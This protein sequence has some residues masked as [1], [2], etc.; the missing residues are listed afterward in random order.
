MRRLAPDEAA[1]W[2]RVIETVKPLKGVVVAPPSNPIPVKGEARRGSGAGVP[3]PSPALAPKPA[4][5]ARAV[6]RVQTL[7]LPEAREGSNTLDGSWDRRLSRGLVAPES[8]I[9]LHGHSLASAHRRL[10]L[11]L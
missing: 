2:K 11:G 9:D 7:P 5:T 10:D 8:S 1:L 3:T 6:A 4:K